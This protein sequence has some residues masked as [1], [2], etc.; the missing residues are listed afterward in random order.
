MWRFFKDSSYGFT[1]SLISYFAVVLPRKI[2]LSLGAFLGG[3][4]YR[5]ASEQRAIAEKHINLSLE[6][7]DGISAKGVV[8]RCFR[9]L[10]K[11]FIEFVRFPHTSSGKNREIV[12]FEGKAHIDRALAQGKGAIILTGHFGNWELLAASLVEQVGPL[13]PI[14]RRLRSRRLDDLVRSWREAAGYSTI[15]RDSAARD[16][17]RCLKRNELIGVLA[18]V[19][20]SVEGVFVDFFGRPA[21]TP[22]SPVAIALKTR[23][24]VLPTFIIRQPDDSH[25]VIVEPPLELKMTGDRDQDALVNTQMFTEI[26]ESYVR[27]YPEQWIWMH[28]RWKRQ[29]GDVIES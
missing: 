25:R 26:I 28:E 10:G 7:K 18:D 9:N 12:T 17:L 6:L 13:T 20:T 16:I 21:H 15:D 14:A 4:A 24:P 1:A 3:V 27:R 8:H 29:P 23:A 22:Y 5:L 2:A 11:N 19:D